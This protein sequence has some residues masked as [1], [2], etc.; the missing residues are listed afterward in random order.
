MPRWPSVV[1]L[2]LGLLTGVSLG[3]PIQ[4]TAA[5]T[6]WTTDH[7]DPARS[8][9]D[10]SD[11]NLGG[12]VN[13][14]WTSPTLD[15]RIYGEPLY[16]NGSVYVATQNN[17]IYAL[18]PNNGNV[19]WSLTGIVRSVPL[20]AVQSAGGVG[21]GCGNIDPM[22]MIGTPV[23]D[24]NRGSAGT[25]Y[26][27]A[28]T[29]DGT[30]GSSIEHRLVV[31]D[32]AGHTVTS[33]ATNVDPSGYTTGSTRAL[34]Q[35]RGA[36]ALA[37]GKV[38][39]PYG[40]LVGDCGNYRG[41]AVSV[42]EDL[43][44]GTASFLADAIH[45]R[46]GIWAT[47]G[48]AADAANNFYVTTG[49]G[50]EPSNQFD[51]SDAVVKLSPTMSVL[52]V[53]APSGWFS[54]N[55][56]DLDLGSMSPILIPR[57]GNPDM[58]FATGK[59]HAGYLL[60]SASLGGIGGQLFAATACD[61]E[62]RG[63]A[64]YSAPFVYVPCTEGIRALTINTATPSFSRT[65]QGPSDAGGP[66]IIAGGRVW[67]HGN[68]RLYGLNASTGATEVTLNGVSTPYNFGS[69]SAGGGRL[70]FPAG[71][72][73]AAF[74]STPPTSRWAG[75]FPM[76]GSASGRVAVA[77]NADGRLE[78]FW[79]DN[80]GSIQHLWQ[81]APASGWTQ[82]F[83]LG[84]SAAGDPSVAKNG[85]GRL[86]AFAVFGDGQLWHA[87]QVTPNGAW[88]SWYPLGGSFTGRPSV[89][90]NRDGRLEAFVR[91]TDNAIWHTWQTAP[92][93]GWTPTFTLG[94]TTAASD[95]A[96]VANADGHL[97]VFARRTDNAL[98]HVW[99]QMPNS[100]WGSWFF[101]S[102]SL[103]GSPAAAI[104]ADGH[105]EA[106]ARGTDNALWH[107][108]QPAP[109]TGWFPFA[110]LGGTFSSNPAV[111]RN[112]TPRLEAFI[113]NN[114]GQVAH[115]WQ[116]QPNGTWVPW[117]T[118]SGFVATS[119]PGVGSNPD[120]RLELLVRGTDNTIW[121]NWQTVPDGGA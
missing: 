63:G 33:G 101:L 42:N 104:N 47:A 29:W 23:I 93:S 5:S 105:M 90:S 67:V 99:Q 43:T 86:E 83:S 85:D 72:T 74:T 102:G 9:N 22:G 114:Q 16:L 51:N 49:N 100:G 46:G 10:T 39:V 108:W 92:N 58:V 53:F 117:S 1:A 45:T 14:A 34:E 79:R 77:S 81:T 17:S 68:N 52:S 95:P 91:G 27:A 28:E 75:W 62:A 76:G 112:A 57:P 89:A 7:L 59:Q 119:P 19:L 98:W 64:A 21:G 26:A 38:V 107:V 88:T 103:T 12:L 73:V 61:G 66:P 32:L 44:G 116:V 94:G 36:L 115:A 35:E 15:G 41:A 106:F 84:G 87:W 110:S 111:G 71:N 3:S 37:G 4:A 82:P 121:H 118:L 55:T 25:L 11:P 30:N 97:E 40:G 96:A 80:S 31:I 65:W 18:D 69:P 6:A 120:G 54:D 48:P 109:N 13:L 20:S 8:G 70:F 2:G 50:S 24:P 78:G 60:N 113:L 56:A